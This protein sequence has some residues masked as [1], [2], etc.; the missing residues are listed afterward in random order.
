MKQV[1]LLIAFIFQLGIQHIQAQQELAVLTYS[2]PEK[3]EAGTPF[4]VSMTLNRGAITGIA[5]I[6]QSWPRGFTINEVENA[7]AIFSFSKKQLQFL[8]VTLP[9]EQE[10]KVTFEVT[11][12]KDYAG[13]LEIPG[14]L[15]Y[16]EGSQRKELTFNPL[17]LD[18]LGKG[19]K[20][21][22]KPASPSLSASS[23]TKIKSPAIAEK[24]STPVKTSPA[25]SPVKKEV[26]PL[27]P[28]P[29]LEQK[30]KPVTPKKESVPIVK[31]EVPKTPET[32]KGA[33]ITEEKPKTEPVKTPA[34]IETTTSP[35]TSTSTSKSAISFRIQVA[36]LP[37]KADKET[38]ARDF[39][40]EAKDLQE[41]SH[42]GLFKYTFGEYPNLAE[43]RKKMNANPK[44]KGKAFIT[45]YRNGIRIDLEEAIRLS[46]EK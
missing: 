41:E 11:A 4:Q 29:K 10:I 32:K 21:F 36:A 17:K 28:A 1:T 27:K 34:K 22:E 19:T 43:A 25:S 14:I 12:S 13:K 16:L 31:K 7:G 37:Q 23:D 2:V 42:N 20:A 45:G 30:E 35:S 3:I 40:V 39:S 18:I 6:Q 15:A 26:A 46:K 38:I 8:W 44:M 24:P 33:P 9:T 5:R